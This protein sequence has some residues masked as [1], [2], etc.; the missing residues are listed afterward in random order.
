LDLRFC[1][2]MK[3]S[4]NS[5]GQFEAD[6]RTLGLSQTPQGVLQSRRS[7][8]IGSPNNDNTKGKRGVFYEFKT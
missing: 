6:G 5:G 8:G 7:A 2:A 4:A 3:S 1:E